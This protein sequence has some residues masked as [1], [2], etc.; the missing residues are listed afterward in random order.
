MCALSVEPVVNTFLTEHNLTEAIM[1]TQEPSIFST[2]EQ[3]KAAILSQNLSP[4]EYQKQI[5]SLAKRLGV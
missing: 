2:Y 3:Q 1:N 5:K 4:E